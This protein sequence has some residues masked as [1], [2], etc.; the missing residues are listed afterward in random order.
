MSKKSSKTG[1]TVYVL[2][3]AEDH[4]PYVETFA[5]E[6]EAE[7]GLYDAFVADF[8]QEGEVVDDV[9]AWLRQEMPNATITITE[10]KI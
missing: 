7:Q 4:D 9:W 2:I 3:V 6:A 8:L 10:K 1:T 5:T